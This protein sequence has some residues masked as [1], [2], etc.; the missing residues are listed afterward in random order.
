MPEKLLKITVEGE[1]AVEVPP[2][3]TVGGALESVSGKLAG[4]SLAASV[5]GVLRDLSYA[6]AGDASITPYDA[7]TPQ[8]L[9]VMRHSA[10][11]VMADAVL[12]L[13]PGAKL[14]I[15]PAIEDGFYYDIDAPRAFTLED[16]PAIEQKMQE[17]IKADLP[18]V[19]R[20]MPRSGARAEME[21]AGEIYKVQ[22]IDAAEGD[23]I[24][25]YRHGGFEDV[26][27][28]PHV[29]STGRIGPV[30]L[31]SVAG[32]YWRGDARNRQLQR[33]YGT[34][35]PDKKQ[36]KQHLLRL[37]EAKKRDHR[38]LGRQ[39]DLFSIQPDI[40]AGLVLWHPAGGTVRHEV[41]EFWLQEH[42][43]RDYRRLY[44]PHIASERIYHKSGHLENYADMMYSPMD[45]DGEPYRVKPMN[46]PAHIMIYKSGIHSYRDLPLR[47]CELGTVYRY[48]P[49]GTLHGML[50]VRGFTQDDSHI[51]CTREQI[52][53]EVFGILDLID[54][55]MNTFG[56]RYSA[57]LATRPEKSLGTDEE[58]DYS[59]DALRNALE[60][61]G[62][63]YEVDEGGGVFYAPKIDIKL[64]DSLGRGWQG[65]T[66]QVDLNL[67]KRFDVT[68]R[69]SDNTDTETVI[70]H[71][72]VLGSMERFVGGL[73]EH[74]GGAFPLWLAPE[75]VR[76]AA[77]TDD[78][79]QYVR[80][81]CAVLRNAGIRAAADLRNE[82][83]GFK[84]REWQMAKVPCLAVA[85]PREAAENLLNLR[86]R[87]EEK[88]PVAGPVQ[89]DKLVQTVLNQVESRSLWPAEVDLRQ[90]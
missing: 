22:N 38:I 58:W 44:T 42:L 35:F 66:I 29:P 49:S 13:F 43:K 78:Q 45:I 80:D 81:A 83:L 8:G 5:D 64:T 33:I 32:A 52:R 26:C 16:L 77:I 61:R 74:Y 62:L 51:F 60:D 46:C 25:F 71:R 2:G 73:V 9:D 48:E 19:R 90:A 23:V 17:I 11:H 28:G 55:M 87:N 27:R 4:R 89:L 76:V 59:T 15:G 36:L 7:S 21:N 57:F 53:S 31:L 6:L 10:S 67:P 40:G 47:Y 18:F 88:A 65:P 3:T 85:G 75:Q 70:I 14:A 41:E 20:E 37:E 50:R 56:Y 63:D 82:K 24:S 68:Y 34:C 69:A 84:V 12:Q 79:A 86:V 1:T 30:K 54:V 39:L 72:T